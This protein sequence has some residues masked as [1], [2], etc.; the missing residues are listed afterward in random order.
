MRSVYRDIN[1]QIMWFAFMFI[2]LNGFYEEDHLVALLVR[3]RL[4]QGDYLAVLHALAQLAL[5]TAKP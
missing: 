5:G 2:S 4:H 3:E 1:I